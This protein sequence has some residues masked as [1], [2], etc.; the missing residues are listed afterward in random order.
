M[1]AV[2]TAA[3][4]NAM[5]IDV[6][7][8]FHVSALAP[9]APRDQWGGFESRVVANTE[10]LLSIFAEADV[11]ATF[12]VLGWVADRYPDL[13]RRIAHAGHEIASH[14]YNHELVYDLTPEQFREDIRRAKA[15][16]ESQTG[17]LVRG[18]RAPSYSITV[19]SLW[20]LDVL[21][22]EGYQY[23]ASI[24][25]VHHDR[26]GI[27][28]AKRH[29]H[30]LE[31]AGGRLAEVPPATVR[32]GSMN[33]PVAG[34][35][36]FR[37]LPYRWTAWGLR[38]L[39]QAERRPAVFYLHPWEIDPMQPRLPAKGL[40]RFRHYHNLH[41]TERRLRRLLAEF[42]FGPIAGLVT[43]LTA[44]ASTAPTTRGQKAAN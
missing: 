21:L 5:S 7:D 6:E 15:L 16:L 32:M 28:D 3:I 12:F 42:V 17:H 39:N 13:A 4:V 37:L 9:W 36:Y 2:E 33:L 26:Y 27:P 34:G 25:P 43:S 22:E 29:A 18:Y 19:K 38:R 40:S 41:R 24:F 14:G 44:G 8:Y 10:R 35:G 31:R 11:T 30:V 1:C 23:D 20:A